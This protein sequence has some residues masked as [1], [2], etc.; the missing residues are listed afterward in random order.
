MTH[1]PTPDE[2]NPQQTA[3]LSFA[4]GAMGVLISTINTLPPHPTLGPLQELAVQAKDAYYRACDVL[5]IT[6]QNYVI[7]NPDRKEGTE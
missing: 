5:G 7:M 4:L 6:E 3:E 1:D 2:L